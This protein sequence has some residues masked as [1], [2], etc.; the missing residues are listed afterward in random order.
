MRK[1]VRERE[2]KT[3]TEQ[4]ILRNKSL[5]HRVRRRFKLRELPFW[6][7]RVVKVDAKPRHCGAAPPVAMF[8]DGG[9]EMGAFLVIRRLLF[10]AV[11]SPL[12][13]TLSMTF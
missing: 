10:L 4:G 13:L 1:G 9:G 6:E 12:T 3:T 5:G 7:S 2:T 11:N 8:G